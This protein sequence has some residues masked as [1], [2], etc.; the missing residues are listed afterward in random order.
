MV[1]LNVLYEFFKVIFVPSWKIPGVNYP[2]VVV[3]LHLD[4]VPWVELGGKIYIL[5]YTVF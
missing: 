1:H 4:Q 2:K 3:R 5:E